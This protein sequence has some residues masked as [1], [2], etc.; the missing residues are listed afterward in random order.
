[1]GTAAALRGQ[2]CLSPSQGHSLGLCSPG[3]LQ[4]AQ[5]T[6]RGTGEQ[7]AL[8]RAQGVSPVPAAVQVGSELCLG[9]AELSSCRWHCHPALQHPRN[10]PHPPAV[11]V[12]E[13]REWLGMAEHRGCPCPLDWRRFGQC[14]IKGG[15]CAALTSGAPACDPL[16]AGSSCQPLPHPFPAFQGKGSLTASPIFCAFCPWGQQELKCSAVALPFLNKMD[17]SLSRA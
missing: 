14:G 8:G 5:G 10:P 4:T 15:L 6:E 13:Q 2:W 1:M 3:A 11:C 9:T 12:S 17:S 16:C 7:Q